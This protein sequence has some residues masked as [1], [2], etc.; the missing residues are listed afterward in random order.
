MPELRFDLF[1]TAA[2]EE[3]ARYRVLDGLQRA[4]KA[5]GRSEVYPH[6]GDLVRL[7]DTL[8]RLTDA[9]SEVRDARP[10]ELSGIDLENGQLVYDQPSEV[11]LLAEALA[12]WAI[13]LMAELIEEG[14]TLFE[15][16]E[17]HAEVR[18]VGI[19]PAYQEE[20]YL[21]VPTDGT[22]HVLR[23]AMSLYDQPDGRYRSLRT[24]EVLATPIDVPLVELKRQL[25]AEH[26]DLPNPATFSIETDVEFPF[27]ATLKPVAKRKLMQYLTL[28]GTHGQA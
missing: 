18:E 14:K 20:G 1:A 27:E 13:P 25:I 7:H 10:G 15:F 23:Y 6:L 19:V 11:P 28:G 17:T 26:A 22:L 12:R 9:A 4:R 21:F 2:D 8:R 16:V 24:S 3:A 5:F